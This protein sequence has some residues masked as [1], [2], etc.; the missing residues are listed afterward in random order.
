MV[1]Y[2]YRKVFIRTSRQTYTTKWSVINI[3]S[4]LFIIEMIEKII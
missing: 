4:T 2:N 3:Y 1:K